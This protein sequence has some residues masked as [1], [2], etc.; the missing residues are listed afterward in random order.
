M[1][2][3]LTLLAVLSG[4]PDSAVTR[5]ADAACNKQVVVLG[6]LP[7]HGEGRAFEAKAAIVKRLVEKCGF[8]AV[9]FE[10]PVYDFVGLQ[11]AVAGM[12]AT[13][14]LLDNAIGR[15]WTARELADWRAWLF[16]RA[17][18]GKVLVAGLDDQISATSQYARATL[19]QLL[20]THLPDDIAAHCQ[21]SVI[22]NLNWQYDAN[23]QYND[24]ERLRLQGCSRQAAQIA[25]GD[26][27]L[28]NLANLYNREQ[29]AADALDRDAMMYRNFLWY[30]QRLRPDSK[31][32]VWTATVHAARQQGVLAA[33][34]LGSWI[35]ESMKDSVAVIG[36]SAFGG[37]SSMAGRPAKVIPDA[38]AGSLEAVATAG[39][40]AW[41]Y[42]DNSALR[43]MGNVPS[44]LF[45]KVM[46][47]AWSQ[48]FDHV[49]VI[50]SEAA[51]TW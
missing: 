50:R 13:Q 25:G 39:D 10:A 28:D 1:I 24:A 26:I 38:P 18:F 7:S 42:L 48:L 51:P 31:L 12:A 15:F 29:G 4:G 44:R 21:A 41:V 3:A 5:V 27:M 19:P 49:L 20:S 6:E 47:A 40:T 46:S 45:G 11:K 30:R 43:R 36:F 8:N 32:I 34:P 23:A 35:A 37:Q 14:T 22:R 16:D 33:K 2:F 17:E 9:L